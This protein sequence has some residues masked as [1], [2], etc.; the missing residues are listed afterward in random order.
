MMQPFVNIAD[1]SERFKDEGGVD[2]YPACTFRQ[3]FRILLFTKELTELASI[4]CASDTTVANYAHLLLPSTYKIL[5]RYVDTHDHFYGV[6]N[7]HF[8]AILLYE[9]HTGE[10]S[11]L[12]CLIDVTSLF[13]HLQM[14]KNK[15]GRF[16][17]CV[18]RFQRSGLRAPAG[19]VKQHVCVHFSEDEFLWSI[20]ILISYLRRQQNLISKLKTTCPKLATSRWESMSKVGGWFTANVS[21]FVHTWPK[22]T[23]CARRPTFGGLHHDC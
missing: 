11:T 21:V 15:T 22:S 19:H 17:G 5:P 18:T 7:V 14:S 6:L 10:R 3:S 13:A 23:R 2:C 20:D 4:G 12:C 9:R 1:G 8:L 16:S